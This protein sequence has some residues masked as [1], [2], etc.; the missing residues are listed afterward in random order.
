MTRKNPPLLTGDKITLMLSLIP[1]LLEYGPTPIKE[2]A[3]HFNVDAQTVRSIIRFFGT[4]GIPGETA[5]YQDEDLF[6]IDWDAL[7]DRDE[8]VLIRTVVVD[9]HP[10]FSAREVAAL[11]AGLQYLTHVPA[12]GDRAE[13]E[14][15]MQK[16]AVSATQA[17]ARV[18]VSS[19][20][21][22]DSLGDIRLAIVEELSVRFGYRDSSGALTTRLVIPQFV[23]SVDDVWYVRGWC[24][25]RQASRLF[26]LDRMIDLSLGPAAN[27]L[28]PPDALADAMVSDALYT[29]SETAVDVL[30]S[31][32]SDRASRLR[33]FDVQETSAGMSVSLA[34]V[35][36][37]FRLAA[38]DPGAVE[39]LAPSAARLAVADWASRALAQYDA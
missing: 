29:P 38:A 26:R 11:L 14:A 34:D 37:A 4:A 7:D 5:T 30:F 32:P 1:Y 25:T 3:E 28:A 33:A 20:S 6:D 31:V 8:A 21:A 15:L 35:G 10:R 16:L 19:A 13:I 23:E 24:T 39:V 22:P 12:I 9:E 27:T 2:L 36:R 18:D 17:A